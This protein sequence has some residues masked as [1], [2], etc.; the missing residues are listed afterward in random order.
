MSASK[1]DVLP[2]QKYSVLAY[3][4]EGAEG[5]ETTAPVRGVDAGGKSAGVLL[6]FR[7]SDN[8]EELL[9][10]AD[11]LQETLK[12]PNV[13]VLETGQPAKIRQYTS[14]SAHTEHE[15]VA[16]SRTLLETHREDMKWFHPSYQVRTNARLLKLLE[17]RAN[18]SSST[19]TLTLAQMTEWKREMEQLQKLILDLSN[20]RERA[21]QALSACDT[22]VWEREELLRLQ[23]L[24]PEDF[25]QEMVSILQTH[26]TGPTPTTEPVPLETHAICIPEI[27]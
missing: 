26:R 16:T 5:V 24:V 8:E 6:F 7:A 20:E 14:S 10:F 25:L 17:D 9:V 4:L 12:I 21:S 13:L 18:G 27:D 1:L 3:Q 19:I 22:T 15:P 23:E 2:G 11:Y